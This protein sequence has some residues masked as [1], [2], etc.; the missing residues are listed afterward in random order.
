[1]APL[2]SPPPRLRV[3]PPLASSLSLGRQ[4]N[5]CF[6]SLSTKQ[7][8]S[9]SKAECQS[10]PQP[11]TSSAQSPRI[12]E[13]PS[14]FIRAMSASQP[15]SD[16]AMQTVSQLCFSHGSSTSQK[17]HAPFN[18]GVLPPWRQ[19]RYPGNR[20]LLLHSPLVRSL[21]SVAEA[22]RGEMTAVVLRSPARHSSAQSFCPIALCHCC[23]SR[24]APSA[25]S[26]SYLLS[27]T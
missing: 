1:M 6:L 18:P 2:L 13:I 11:P 12:R 22:V 25:T 21:G 9:S 27:P 4:G 15:A 14:L 23:F 20:L 5:L 24:L 26:I 16:G 7:L 17:T 3:S 8:S 19:Q 10:H